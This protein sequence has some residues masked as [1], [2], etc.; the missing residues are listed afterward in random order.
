MEAFAPDFAQ[1]WIADQASDSSAARTA[2]FDDEPV[3][4]SQK[5]ALDELAER[6]NAARSIV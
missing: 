1:F 6:I 5:E 4:E 2:F 3:S